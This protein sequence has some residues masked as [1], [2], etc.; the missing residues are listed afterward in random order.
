[1]KNNNKIKFVLL[2]LIT[3]LVN[4]LFGSGGGTILVPGL[5]FLFGIAEHKAH[6]TAISV[7][8]PLALI[9]TIVYMK[10]GIIVW[11]ITLKVIA[12]GV[13]GAFIGAKLL[14]KIPEKILRKAFA[15]FM[16]VAAIRM[17]I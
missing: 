17:V 15:I 11:D 4:G 3:G 16:I 8:L 14:N 5:F 1:M 10:N 7:I 2:G 9:S 13:I 12:G 6:A